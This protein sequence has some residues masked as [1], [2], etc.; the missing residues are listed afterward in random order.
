MSLQKV[1]FPHNVYPFTDDNTIIYFTDPESADLPV[2]A[3]FTNG[4]Y[5]GAELAAELQTQMNAVSAGSPFTVT[6]S[7]QT[8]KFTF[9]V[10]GGTGVVSF[11][12]GLANANEELG[13][14][15]SMF[16]PASAHTSTYPVNLSGPQ[17]V[18]LMTNFSTHNYS[19]SS[20][21]NIFARIPLLETFGNIIFYEP[22]T[23]DP[24]FVSETQLNTV[25]VRLMNDKGVFYKLPENAHFSM[26]LKIT[27]VLEGQAEGLF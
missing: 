12:S 14:G 3:T 18:D 17:Y 13:I 16:S 4:I 6:F 22:H 1:E 8:A 20:A 9:A 25:T 2:F 15:E 21:P 7:D 11:Y 10:A 5:T 24:L 27:P 19:V 26:T 23:D